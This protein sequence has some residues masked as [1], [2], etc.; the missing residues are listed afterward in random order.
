MRTSLLGPRRKTTPT[1]A[2]EANKALKRGERVGLN[3]SGERWFAAGVHL[4]L[5]GVGELEE[6]GLAPGG[7]EERQTDGQA[8][9][10]SGGDGDVRVAGD[11]CWSGAATGVAIAVDVVSEPSGAG[12]QGHDCI[13]LVL[14]EQGVN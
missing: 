11:S 7:G 9:I 14:G 13:E 12:G 5:P 1:G 10:E 2:C 8:A 6:R 4:L 3:T